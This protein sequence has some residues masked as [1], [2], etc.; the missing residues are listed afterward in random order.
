[1]TI[2]EMMV[3]AAARDAADSQ[4]LRHLA[5]SYRALAE[6][7]KAVTPQTDEGRF[8]VRDLIRQTNLIADDA[9]FAAD[10][11]DQRA[12]DILERNAE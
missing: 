9:S 2:A 7:L 8:A 11:A 12:Q 3:R 5:V 1:M 4:T 6:H 10:D